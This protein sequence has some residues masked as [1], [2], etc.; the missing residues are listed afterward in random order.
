MTVRPPLSAEASAV[1][2]RNPVVLQEPGKN[3]ARF[4]ESAGETA[5]NC[6]VVCCCC[7]CGL[8]NLLVV[9]AVKLP[10][11]LVRRA[12]RRRTKH[13]RKK[14]RLLWARARAFDEEEEE[15]F[16]IHSAGALLAAASHDE[17]WPE[18]PPSEQVL[19]LEKVMWASFYGAGFWRSPSQR[20]KLISFVS[21]STAEGEEKS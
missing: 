13:Q 19:E 18:K 2:R 7:P 11:G 17:L 10:A 14:A 16:S 20:E 21:I 15:F 4:A 5:A 1:H 12:L 6:A 3:R 8:V 9:V